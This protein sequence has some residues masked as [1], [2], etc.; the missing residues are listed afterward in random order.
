MYNNTKKVSRY[1]ICKNVIYLY[2]DG[3]TIRFLS[4][5]FVIVVH[6]ELNLHRCRW[7]HVLIFV[8]VWYA[9]ISRFLVIHY[10]PCSFRRSCIPCKICWRV[11]LRKSIVY[12]K[13]NYKES[14]QKI[15]RW[16]IIVWLQN[17]S[18]IFVVV[19]VDNCR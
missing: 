16:S 13:K 4:T 17:F 12:G 19:L 7:R 5:L 6:K 10:Q 2:I 18:S 11:C 9:F 8:I 15:V 14:L 1:E 3:H